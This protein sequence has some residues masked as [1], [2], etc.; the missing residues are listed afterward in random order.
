M[1]YEVA[2]PIV[3]EVLRAVYAPQA[4]GLHHIPEQGAAILASNHLSGA[5]TVFMPAQVRRTVHFLAKS[6]FFAGTSLPSRALGALLCGLGVMPVDR[7]GGN[8][9]HSALQGAL[10]VLESG[11][12]LGIYP[13]GTRSPDGRLHRGKT[14]MA[15]LALATGAP[16]IPIG[17]EGSFEAQRGRRIIPRRRPRII[18]RVGAPIMP[19]SVAGE[20]EGAHEDAARLRELT[21]LVMSRIQE[22][23]GQEYVDLYAAD[24]KRGGTPDGR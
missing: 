10:D 7:T 8:A 18:V 21:D 15:R 2:K 19:A 22:L 14:G 5:D 23:T 12:L 24:V 1:L 11:G 20:G 9:S 6:D 16:I 17:M 3:R 4:H 13:E